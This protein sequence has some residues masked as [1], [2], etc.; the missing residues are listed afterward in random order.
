MQKFVADGVH[1]MGVVVEVGARVPCGDDMSVGPSATLREGVGEGE[2]VVVGN[3]AVGDGDLAA[4][5]AYPQAA[6]IRLT[7]I[8]TNAIALADFMPVRSPRAPGWIFR[9]LF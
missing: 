2:L 5:A 4:V 3:G 6:R 9:C 1:G 8:K 7:A